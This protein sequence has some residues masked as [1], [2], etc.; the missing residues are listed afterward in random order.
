MSY[1][2][3]SDVLLIIDSGMDP[4]EIED[5]ITLADDDLDK[6]SAGVTLD[7]ADKKKG[8]MYLAAIMIAEKQPTSYTVGT[9]RVT[10]DG[11]AER[12]RAKVQDIIRQ[13]KK[14]LQVVSSTYQ[15]IDE[16]TRYPV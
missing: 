2:K 6:M 9:A 1:C 5:L 12:W 14:T 11:R 15:K 10:H 8:S 7:E 3:P 13:N 16:N 4:D